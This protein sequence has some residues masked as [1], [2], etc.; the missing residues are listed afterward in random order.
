MNACLLFGLVCLLG[1]HRGRLPRD[2]PR[3]VRGLLMLYYYDLDFAKNV[4]QY[5]SLLIELQFF[6]VDSIASLSRFSPPT[7]CV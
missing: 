1:R 3:L 2:E 7:Q 4:D 5:G 6:V